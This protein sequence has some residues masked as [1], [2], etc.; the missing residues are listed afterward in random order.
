MEHRLKEV[1]EAEKPTEELQWSTQEPAVGQKTE[2]GVY[3]GGKPTWAVKENKE[4]RMNPRIFA[5]D[6]AFFCLFYF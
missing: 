5:L 4:T 6:K 2:E 3:F 1:T